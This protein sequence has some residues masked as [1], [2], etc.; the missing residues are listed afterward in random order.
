M[1]QAADRKEPGVREY[2]ASQVFLHKL[3]YG[4][5]VALG[6]AVIVLAFGMALWTWIAAG[7]YVACGVAGP[8]WMIMFICPHCQNYGRSCPCG[9]GLISAKLRRKGE[10]SLFG[11]KFRR[12]IPAI[13]PL[14]IIPVA[15][16]GVA[17]ATGFSWWLVALTAAFLVE[18]FV[19]LPLVAS[20]CECS[21]CDQRDMC[22]WVRWQ[23]AEG[24]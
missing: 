20:K 6:A 13:V 19:V 21:R 4:V 17:L 24:K 15:A 8:F 14:W 23:G 16:G 10:T 2:T 22:P 7:V 1:T 12:Y 9:Y 18:S 3:P 5:M 11:A